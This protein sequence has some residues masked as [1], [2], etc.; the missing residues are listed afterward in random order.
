MRAPNVTGFLKMQSNG[1]N[2]IVRSF[3]TGFK[4][5][6]KN[7]SHFVRRAKEKLTLKERAMAPSQGTAIGVGNYIT[8]LRE[9]I[10]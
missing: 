3:K 5:L 8:F 7:E 2:T 6:D 1:G 9:T 4:N 10:V